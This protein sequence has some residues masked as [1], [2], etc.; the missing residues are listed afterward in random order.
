MIIEETQ[1][2]QKYSSDFIP[3]GVFSQFVERGPIP[4][5]IVRPFDSDQITLKS[6]PG[7][8]GGWFITCHAVVRNSEEGPKWF[9]TEEDRGIVCIIVRSQHEELIAN[10]L[11]VSSIRIIAKTKSGKSVLCEVVA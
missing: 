3:P 7:N 2:E 8:E 11:Q 6:E 5:S 4:S 1:P 10:D 9:I